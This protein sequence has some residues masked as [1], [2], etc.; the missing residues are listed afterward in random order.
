MVFA[1]GNSYECIECNVVFD[2]K[3]GQRLS[4]IEWHRR[5]GHLA[6]PGLNL[7]HGM[8]EECNM[9]K[10]RAPTSQNPSKKRKAHHAPT[11]PL[12]IVDWDFAG[13]FVQSL[14][15]NQYLLMSL[16]QYLNWYHAWPIRHKDE[17]G[18]MLSK[19][20]KLYGKPEFCRQD[21]EPVFKGERS[22]WMLV[23]TKHGIQ[24]LFSQPYTPQANGRIERMMDT[25][26]N[27]MRACLT[28]VDRRLWDW[29][30]MFVVWTFNRV[31][32]REGKTAFWRR[33]G[34]VFP[35]KC[36]KRF[37]CLAYAKIQKED[38][39]TALG[40]CYNRGVFLGY[41]KNSCHLVGRWVLDGR[42]S[43]PD[44][45]IWKV[46]EHRFCKFDETRTIR[47][48]DLLKL[49]DRSSADL[50]FAPTQSLSESDATSEFDVLPSGGSSLG[51][52]G[53]VPE[54]ESDD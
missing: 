23:M 8:C 26:K 52:G 31:V 35:I 2:Q 28:F 12:Q 1:K 4:K 13:P 46:E 36:M 11:A 34:R 39:D 27:N 40:S 9:G 22:P 14:E 6:V 49:K 32:E 3:I 54:E 20:V 33:F 16:D 17:N 7:K 53:R 42:S 5:F 30:A 29:C 41:S 25:V 48:V 43:A 44:K 37:G 21:N 38:R 15:G 24:P 47:N 45:L 18:S 51:A 10:N 19:F 50:P